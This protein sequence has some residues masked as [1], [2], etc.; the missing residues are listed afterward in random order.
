[1]SGLVT[2]LRTLTILPVKGRDA[3]DFAESLYWFPVAGLLTGMLTY[4]PV[5][6]ISFVAG[7]GWA[8]ATALFAVFLSV[9][10]TRGLHLDGLSDWADGFW[11]SSSPDRILAI[12]KDSATGTFGALSLILV[13]LGK[14]VCITRLIE[15]RG[16][17]ALVVA[18]VVSRSMQAVLA[19]SFPYARAEGGT[20]KAFVSTAGP[21]HRHFALAGGL[22]LTLTAG[23][24]SP[25]ASAI[26]FA[27]AWIMAVYMGR[28]SHARI[29]GITGDILGA[30]NEMVETLVLVA[31]CILKQAG[32]S[33]GTC[34]F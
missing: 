7:T 32:F 13:L 25:C 34:Y 2:A 20:A 31:F 29:G 12:M 5:A 21:R 16:A 11:G 10:L 1:M 9:V 6:G 14:W 22:A 24:G 33:S 18:C 28:W 23:A 19:A 15:I 30:V 8:E 17:Y 26:A 3:E 4:L 27:L